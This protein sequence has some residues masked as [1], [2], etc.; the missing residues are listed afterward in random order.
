MCT[1]KVVF[2]SLPLSI[3]VLE[4]VPGVNKRS[5]K[6]WSYKMMGISVQNWVSL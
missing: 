5:Y 2:Y 1:N 3:G 6:N 4:I